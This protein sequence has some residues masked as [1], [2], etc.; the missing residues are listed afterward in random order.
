MLLV[1]DKITLIQVVEVFRGRLSKNAKSK[2]LDNVEGQGSGSSYEKV[3]AERLVRNLIERNIIKEQ[4]VKSSVGFPVTYIYLDEQTV[5]RFM[6]S[7]EKIVLG[8]TEKKRASKIDQ[9]KKKRRDDLQLEGDE[10]LLFKRLD[11]LRK[12]VFKRLFPVHANFK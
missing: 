9:V 7:G 11:S 8:F 6:A 12:K 1:H 2:G 3:D 10:E 4:T 5:R